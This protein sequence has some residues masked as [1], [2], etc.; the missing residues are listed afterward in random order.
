MSSLG[1]DMLST[2]A[3]LVKAPDGLLTTH[4]AN[5]RFKLC[6]VGADGLVRGGNAIQYAK[7]I[8]VC[9]SGGLAIINRKGGSPLKNERPI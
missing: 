8:L 7:M 2:R 4:G 9:Q 1:Q 5:V 6:V 3:S